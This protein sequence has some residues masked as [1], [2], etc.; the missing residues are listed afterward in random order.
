MSRKQRRT[1]AY[2][3]LQR[4]ERELEKL[5]RFGGTKEQRGWRAHYKARRREIR[6]E[7]FSC[8]LK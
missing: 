7:V 6:R 8:I 5:P 2:F 4:V 3:E 1:A